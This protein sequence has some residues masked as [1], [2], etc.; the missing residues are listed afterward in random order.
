MAANNG[1]SDSTGRQI[2]Y[3]IAYGMLSTNLKEIPDGYEEIKESVLKA[4]T[5]KVEN[6]D[7]RMKYIEKTGNYPY[8]CFFN[9]ISGEIQSIDKDVYDKGISLKVGILDQDG[10]SS[11]LQ[12]KFYGKTSADFLNRLLSVNNTEAM[13]DFTPYSIPSEA[14]IN[15]ANRKFYNQGVSI[16]EEGNKVA[17]SFNKDN[18]LPGTEQIQDAEGK[19]VTSR[20][21]QV[22]FLWEKVQSKFAALST[23]SGT[24]SQPK[25]ESASATAKPA[26]TAGAV[27]S[28]DDLP[29]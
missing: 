28:N 25:Q 2:Y 14:E 7:L 21:K 10:D 16:R 26:E 13:L 27:T 29:F 24:D 12:T 17:R 23:D 1:G 3:S 19:D 20:V 6:V 4:K 9:N 18:G 15:G 22:N 11:I 5:E 8:K